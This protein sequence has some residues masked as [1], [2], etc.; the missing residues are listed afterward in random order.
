MRLSSGKGIVLLT[1]FLQCKNGHALVL[2]L[3]LTSILST[4]TRAASEREDVPSLDLTPYHL[5]YEASYRGFNAE[6]TRSF[7]PYANNQFRMNSFTELT[8]FG[9]SIVSIRELS[10]FDVPEDRLRPLS[11]SFTQ[12]GIGSRTRRLHF[13]NES[14][15]VVA[16][17]NDKVTSLAL[18]GPVLDEQNALLHLRGQ[19]RLGVTD[20]RF[21]V[22]DRDKLEEN[23][24][25]VSGNDRIETSR[26]VFNT[27]RVERIRSVESKRSTTLW[28]APDWGYIVVKLVQTDPDNQT[29]ELTLTE[30][31]YGEEIISSASLTR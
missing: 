15:Q 10:T 16:T 11:Y 17:V 1:H 19:V 3:M 30:G 25:Q 4:T 26:G 27:V 2:F 7:A 14:A 23:R 31:T 13:E 18:Q 6:A 29:L 22:V 5:K 28:L 12:E 9:R 20:I 8:L 24:Y 21:T